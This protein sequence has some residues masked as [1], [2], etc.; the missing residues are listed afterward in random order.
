MRQRGT[1]ACQSSRLAACASNQDSTRKHRLQREVLLV[2]KADPFARNVRGLTALEVAK[3][4]RQRAK[5]GKGEFP[6]YISLQF[7][8]HI[9][10]TVYVAYCHLLE[11][12]EW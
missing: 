11:N 12:D 5:G 10:V 7:S 8:R 4:S 9:S 2:A 1:T 6:L 3:N